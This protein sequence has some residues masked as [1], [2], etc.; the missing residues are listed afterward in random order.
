MVPPPWEGERISSPSTP[1]SQQQQRRPTPPAPRNR[2]TS[3]GPSPARS[4]EVPA[5]SSSAAGFPKKLPPPKPSKPSALTTSSSQIAVPQLSPLPAPAHPRLPGVS[6]P[7]TKLIL[8]PGPPFPDLDERP[9]PLPKRQG[10]ASSTASFVS[11]QDSVA[12]APS[13]SVSSKISAGP[14]PPPARVI[15][16][17]QQQGRRNDG[18]G[19][20]DAPAPPLPP[21]RDTATSLSSTALPVRNGRQGDASARSSTAGL[22]DDDDESGRGGLDRRYKPLVPG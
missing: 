3:A 11:A 1:T 21:R 15:K 18:A 5:R 8:P 6:R 22:M 20:D 19:D 13:M 17:S 2:A 12:P 9:P 7:D 16:L 10:T 4:P 14:P